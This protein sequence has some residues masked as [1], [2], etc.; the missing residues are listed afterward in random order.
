MRSF[1]N[2]ETFDPVPGDIVTVLRRID[3]ASGAEARYRDQLPQLL[4]ALGEQARV[5][6]VTAS[7]AI[8]GVFVEPNR[9]AGLVTGRTERFR[10]RNE[11]EFAGYRAALD[12]LNQE[13]PGPLNAGLLLHLH[14]L[15]LQ[16]TD[17]R[18]GY[19]KTDENRVMDRHDDGSRTLRF[20]PVSPQETPYFV[21]ELVART[22]SAL[23]D[24]ALH[25]L[26]VVGAFALDLL[27]IHPFADGNGRVTRLVTSYLLGQTGYG[28]GRY[29]SIEQLIYDTKDDYYDAL[30]ASTKGWFDDG[31]HSLWPWAGYMLDQLSVAYDRFES[32]VAA[33]LSPG[34]KQDR[35]RDFVLLHGPSTFRI[36]D[37]RSAVPG[38]TDQTIRVVLHELRDA[39]QIVSDGAGRSSSWH[40]T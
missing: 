30:G 9:V 32:R 25:P 5:E 13:D 38:V 24:G 35:V 12:Y 19:F 10:N 33:G 37:I 1:Q 28:V 20:T 26:L 23:D 34:T 14:R 2:V 8:E 16:F 22:N 17:G 18:G 27:C 21:E 39:G 7:S 40:R 4:A 31:K 15:L 3:R 36:A 11:K 29:V 6:S